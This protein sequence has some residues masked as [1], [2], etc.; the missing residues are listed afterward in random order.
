MVVRS[1]GYSASGA[2][3]PGRITIHLSIAAGSKQP[4]VLARPLGAE[5]PSVEIEGPDGV[6]VAAY[7]LPVKITSGPADG[8]RVAGSTPLDFVVVV[9]PEAAC[10]GHSLREA[11]RNSAGSGTGSSTLTVAVSDPAIARQRAAH[12]TDAASSLLIASWP[13]VPDTAADY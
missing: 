2:S 4:L 13:P 6:E 10:P 3:D 11:R 7:G 12:G 9:P 5:G 1:Y 8:R